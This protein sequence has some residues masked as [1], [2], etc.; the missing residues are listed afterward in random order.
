MPSELTQLTTLQ[1]LD[2]RF[3]ENLS[4]AVPLELHQLPLSTLD[5]MA[6]SVCIP[7]DAELQEWLATIEFV[8][9]GLTCGRPADAMSSIDILVVYTPAARKIAGGDAEIEAHID[10]MIAETNQVYIDSGVNQRVALVAR[11][12]VEYTE[13]GSTETDLTRLK[14]ATDGYMDEVH[15]IRDPVRG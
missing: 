8:T 4:G 2:L 9:S 1:K 15:A 10:L 5:L 6:T 7:A 13:S 3:N 14:S 11:E 12:E